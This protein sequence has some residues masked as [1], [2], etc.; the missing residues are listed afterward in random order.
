[1]DVQANPPHMLASCDGALTEAL[2][3]ARVQTAMR[4]RQL[5]KI[6]NRCVQSAWGVLI[7]WQRPPLQM[8]KA[9]CGMAPL[10]VKPQLL[11][12]ARNE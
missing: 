7:S 5:C 6:E 1:M 9:I 10:P 8:L 11:S 3:V 2:C 12:A 4:C